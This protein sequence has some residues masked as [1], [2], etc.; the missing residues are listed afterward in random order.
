[1]GRFDSDNPLSGRTVIV[2]RA[3]A[4]AAAFSDR[5]AAYG[6]EVLAFPTIEI[7]GPESW[8]P[9]DEAISDLSS[10]DWVVFSSVNAVEAFFGRMAERGVDSRALTGC[11]IAAVGPATASACEDHGITAD[12]VPDRY[13]AEGL[14]EGFLERGVG[15]GTRFLLP[16]A[17]KAREV[18]PETLRER[19]AT[20]DV[21]VVYRTV[22]G[23]GDSAVM[24][25]IAAG[26]VDAIT[27]TSSST[28]SNFARL[29]KEML[30]EDTDVAALMDGVTV[31][32]IGPVTSKTAREH[33]L[34]VAVEPKE[35]T[36]EGLADALAA[37]L[38][39]EG[40]DK[41]TT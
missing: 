40:A 18:L 27:F 5:L 25:R 2:T 7:V 4:Q 41:L 39:N 30:G 24:E 11:R 29:A 10:Y 15:E 28:V 14:I 32:S 22:A 34:S 3:R 23:K 6:A 21:A 17:L 8:E 13:V 9:V 16:R 33:G 19:G 1:M 12:Y 20:V 38:A 36:V 35:H 26:G 37:H 31:A